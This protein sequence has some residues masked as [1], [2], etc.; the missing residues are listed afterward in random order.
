MALAFAAVLPACSVKEQ[1]QAQSDANQGLQVAAV[2][3]KLAAV[4]IDATTNVHV[5]ANG[6]TITL[7]GQAH[8]NA[9]RARYVDAAK[10]VNGVRAVVDDLTVNPHVTGVREQT[11]DATLTARVAAA[12]A[13][14][15]GVNVFHVAPSSKHGVVTLRGTVPSASVEKTIVRTVRG[16][17]GVRRVIDRLTIRRT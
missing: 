16:V 3:A 8:S 5:S 9:E 13:G 10:S 14:Q 15:A 1:Q 4:D 7:K 2:T 12:I 17:P 11:L 6:G